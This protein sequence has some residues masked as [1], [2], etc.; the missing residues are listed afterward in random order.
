MQVG[1]L[2]DADLVCVFELLPALTVI[3]VLPLVSKQ[4]RRIAH[5][6]D[7]WRNKLQSLPPVSHF[8]L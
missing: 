3:K 6:A 2:P 7:L 4:F 5:S 1:D 8:P